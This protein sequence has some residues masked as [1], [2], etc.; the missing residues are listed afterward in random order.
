MAF[1][2]SFILFGSIIFNRRDYRYL[3]S[4][5]CQL[6]VC[7]APGLASP[8]PQAWRVLK[9][10]FFKVVRKLKVWR[11]I[12]A[13]FVIYYFY[14]SEQTAE[15]HMGITLTNIWWRWWC[16][17]CD[18]DEGELLVNVCDVKYRFWELKRLKSLQ[19]LNN[20]D[21]DPGGQKWVMTHKNRKR[22]INFT[23][24]S[25]GCSLLSAEGFSPVLSL[26]S[27]T[28]PRDK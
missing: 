18:I 7:L 26:T 22:F 9:Q 6:R 24:W 11:L 23:F 10:S 13:L 17:W 4:R 25:A 21:P 12:A 8:S 3:P 15:R 5:D 27:Y 1:L 20:L 14:Y 16:R 19:I 28:R 2:I